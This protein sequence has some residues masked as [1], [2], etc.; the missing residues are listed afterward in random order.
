[1]IKRRK[2]AAMRAACGGRHGWRGGVRPA[3]G[4]RTPL[5][6]PGRAGPFTD[7]QAQAGQAVY[8]RPLRR[9]AMRPAAKPSG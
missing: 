5:R 8:T 9:P 6:K 2:K 4:R 3:C 7:A 1:M